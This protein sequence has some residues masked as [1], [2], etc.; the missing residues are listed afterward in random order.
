MKIDFVKLIN[1]L[2]EK[3]YKRSNNPE[4]PFSYSTNGIV[5]VI[6][7]NQEI[8]WTSEDCYE[9]QEIL[10][11]IFNKLDDLLKTLKISFNV[12][13]DYIREKDKLTIERG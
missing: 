12:V 1:D 5:E 6:M 4:S 2:N 11:Q 10:E 13:F 9:Y 3:Y 8:L 7:F